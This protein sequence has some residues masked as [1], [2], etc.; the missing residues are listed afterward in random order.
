MYYNWLT[1]ITQYRHTTFNL[2]TLKDSFFRKNTN[3]NCATGGKIHLMETSRQIAWRSSFS[4]YPP[5]FN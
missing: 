3:H 4:T 1:I 5:P 2:F